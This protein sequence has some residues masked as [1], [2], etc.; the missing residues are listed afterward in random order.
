MSA[1]PQTPAAGKPSEEA[2]LAEVA[3]LVARAR[4]AQQASRVIPRNRP[5][6]W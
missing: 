6:N 1:K 2:M 5:T 3:E 4:K